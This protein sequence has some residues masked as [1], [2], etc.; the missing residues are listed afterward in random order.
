MGFINFLTLF[1]YF[2]Y[3]VLF[4]PIY[5]VNVVVYYDNFMYNE[6][7]DHSRVK[8]KLRAVMGFV[9]EMYA[10]KDTLKTMVKFNTID[11][12]HDEKTSFG[13]YWR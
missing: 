13:D 6:Y 1:N 4:L 2:I 10:E 8:G 5:R 3:G 12:L 11:I 9:N 7:R